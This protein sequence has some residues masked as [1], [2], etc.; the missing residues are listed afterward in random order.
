MGVTWDVEWVAETGSTNADLLAAARGG[1]PEGRV[2]S[3]DHQTAGRGRLGR[4]WVAPSGASL[5]CSVLVRP[6]IP[7]TRVH[8][9][10]TALALAAADAC[11]SLA[12]VAPDLKWPNDLLVG[13]RKLGGVLAESVVE[14]DHLEALV[15][16]IG[17]NVSWPEEL[18]DD[19]A[20]IA[21]ALNL[22]G[23]HDVDRRVLLGAILEGFATRYA[24][25]GAGNVE[26]LVDEARRRT[27]TLG[28]AVLVDLGNDTLVGDAVD[29]TLDGHLVVESDGVRREVTAGD[30]VH[31]RPHR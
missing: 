26:A 1:A 11:G 24:D 18:P 25:L 12:G 4:S 7:L 16:G 8:L 20:E 5:L 6:A 27:A 22:E 19:L 14:G 21:T 17:L 15:I 31:L 2:L 28:Q 10:T 3:A 23:G 9:V 29:I 13:T 30:V